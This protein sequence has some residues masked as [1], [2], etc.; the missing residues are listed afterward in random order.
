MTTIRS[1]RLVVSAAAALALALIAGPAIGASTVTAPTAPTAT[2][3]NSNPY[4]PEH[5]TNSQG[6]PALNTAN[7]YQPASPLTPIPNCPPGAMCAAPPGTTP[8]P[9]TVPTPSPLPPCVPR[10]TKACPN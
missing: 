5:G 10:A 3:P 6:E 7:Q 8:T 2:M 1:G 9:A 4:T